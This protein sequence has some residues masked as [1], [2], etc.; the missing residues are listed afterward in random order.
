MRIIRN[1]LIIDDYQTITL[2]ASGKPL[3]VA[4]SRSAPNT[5]IDIWSYD[6]ESGD[7]KS[8]GI[9]IV[10]TGHPMPSEIAMSAAMG[11]MGGLIPIPPPFLGT[12]VTP[13][14]LVW[15]VFEGP[16]R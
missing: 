5:L 6:F 13:I 4:Q 1:E 16:V 3:S 10:G 14:G 2:P 7:P 12:V 9:Y 15:H 8:I 11:G